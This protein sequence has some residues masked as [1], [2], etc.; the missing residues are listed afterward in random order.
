MSF[1]SST[2]SLVTMALSQVKTIKKLCQRSSKDAI[3]KIF[4]YS[5]ITILSNAICSCSLTWKTNKRWSMNLRNKAFWLESPTRK[6][7]IYFIWLPST[8]EKKPSW[9]EYAR[10]SISTLVIFMETPLYTIVAEVENKTLSRLSW[11]ERQKK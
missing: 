3:S 9:L 10:K 1:P 6:V 8:E 5:M 4:S 2:L 7:K 11:P